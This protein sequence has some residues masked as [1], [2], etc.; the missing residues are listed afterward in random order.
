MLR[1]GVEEYAKIRV[2]GVGGGGSNAVDRDEF[3]AG[4][5][6]IVL[7]W[8]E[9]GAFFQGVTS[10]L[11]GFFGSTKQRD[12][13][14]VVFFFEPAVDLS[15]LKTLPRLWEG[16][17]VKLAASV[18]VEQGLDQRAKSSAVRHQA[19]HTNFLPPARTLAMMMT[20]RDRES[21]PPSAALA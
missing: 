17:L 12:K 15:N 18:R 11:F 8:V 16:E 5:K 9:Q 6:S 4:L 7:R 1:P 13:N 14:G 3:V 19:W 10:S 21:A 20:P 2:V